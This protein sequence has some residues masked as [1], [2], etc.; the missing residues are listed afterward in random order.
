MVAFVERMP[1][2]PL[3]EQFR[4]MGWITDRL[5]G[6]PQRK[7]PLWWWCA[8]AISGSVALFGIFC[9]LYLLF[10][11]VGV[12][13]KQYSRGL[14]LGYYQFRVLDRNRSRRHIDLCYSLSLPGP[15][16]ADSPWS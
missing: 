5:A 16:L 8:I 12:W 10:T 7:T 6:I 14:G 11:G 15:S 3:V 13:G 2:P 1:R 9:I 4:S